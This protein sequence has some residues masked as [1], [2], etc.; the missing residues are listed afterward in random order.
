MKNNEFFELNCAINGGKRLTIKI[1]M[2]VHSEFQMDVSNTNTEAMG[3]LTEL[4]AEFAEL[5][6]IKRQTFKARKVF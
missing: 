6:N 3:H 1:P 2:S 5:D 4:F